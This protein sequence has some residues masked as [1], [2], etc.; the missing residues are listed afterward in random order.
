MDEPEHAFVIELENGEAEF[1]DEVQRIQEQPES[2]VVRNQP[3]AL[4]PSYLTA[5]VL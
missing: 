1:V 3:V 4:D 5:A 2:V